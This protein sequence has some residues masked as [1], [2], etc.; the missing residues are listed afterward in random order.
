MLLRAR[1][2]LDWM[3]LYTRF[4]ESKRKNWNL[5]VGGSRAAQQHFEQTLCGPAGTS[6]RSFLNRRHRISRRVC[7][8]FKH[9]QYG[10]DLLKALTGQGSDCPCEIMLTSCRRG[11]GSD[12]LKC[13]LAVAACDTR[14]AC[15]RNKAWAIDQHP[16]LTGRPTWLPAYTQQPRIPGYG[17][18]TV[19][20]LSQPLGRDELSWRGGGASSRSVGLIVCHQSLLTCI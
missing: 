15:G 9:N 6:L 1:S 10:S 20:M 18:T 13:P 17:T 5:V 3:L 8:I 16:V 19:A 12:T 14:R 4:L 2:A 7:P 11:V